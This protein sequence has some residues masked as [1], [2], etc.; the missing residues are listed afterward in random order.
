M[1]PPYLITRTGRNIFDINNEAYIAAS[2][3]VPRDASEF[4]ELCK[5]DAPQN[6]VKW[7]MNANP[8]NSTFFHILQFSSG[9]NSSSPLSSVFTRWNLE[10]MTFWPLERINSFIIHEYAILIIDVVWLIFFVPYFLESYDKSPY[11]NVNSA[12]FFSK[13]R[14]KV[15]C[16]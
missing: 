2:V 3:N 12:L 9:P 5:F 4:T 13:V 11:L 16:L 1:K 8:V 14:G 7:I 10:S 15:Y 6:A